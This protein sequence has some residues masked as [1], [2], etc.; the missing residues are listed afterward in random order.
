M[1]VTSPQSKQRRRYVWWGILALALALILAVAWVG[2]RGFLAKS[3]LESLSELS[4]EF[5]TALSEQDFAQA[6]PLVDEIGAHAARATALTGDPV[7]AVAE[8]VPFIGPNL[9]AARLSA[10]QTD[11]VL[12]DGAKPVLTAVGALKDGVGADGTLDASA[13]AKLVPQL[14]VASVTVGHASAELATIDQS[15]VIA[16]LASAVADL[17][18]ALAQMYPAVDALARASVLLPAMLGTDQPTSI[19]VMA[20]NNA[21]LRTGGGITGTFIELEA[22]AGRVQIIEQADSSNFPVL[23]E[24]LVPIPESTTTLYGDSV[25]R[26][27]QNASMP[28]DFELTAALAQARWIEHT[29]RTPSIIVS[30][31]PLVL[32]ALL[33]AVGPVQF[34]GAELTTENVVQRLLVEPYLTLD[35]AAQGVLFQEAVSAVFDRVS[36]GAFDPLGVVEALIVPVQQGRISLWAQDPVLQASIAGTDLAGPA[37]RQQTAG[38]SAF[39]VYFNDA[40]GGKMGGFL[41]TE[42]SAGVERCHADGLVEVVVSVTLTSNAPADAEQTL[43]GSVTGDRRTGTDIGIGIGIGD[44]GTLITVAAPPGYFFG[45]VVNEGKAVRSGDVIDAG[46]PSSATRINISPGQTKTA[47]FTFIAPAP[48][49]TGLSVLHTPMLIDPTVTLLPDGCE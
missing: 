44:I 5:K 48:D 7:W 10:S 16:P 26:W 39:A 1:S 37:G 36:A 8:L 27:V 40:T 46:F 6:L 30:L 24:P 15:R 21:E 49:V 22:N 18:E 19:L 20:Q 43:P 42:I 47:Q 25:G 34:A 3:E 35:A 38:D 23:T 12:R 33:T 28:A 29:G 9:H 11:A 41:G 2:T 31:D 45:G 14:H 17:S 13:L 32:R 4:H